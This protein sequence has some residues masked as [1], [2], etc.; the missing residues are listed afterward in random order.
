MGASPAD[1]E[2]AF[3]VGAV[4]EGHFLFTLDAGIAT[5]LLVSVG[6]GWFLTASNS[7]SC[8]NDFVTFLDEWSEWAQ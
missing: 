7:S 4:L 3:C 2:D 6:G 5:G 8:Q 1:I